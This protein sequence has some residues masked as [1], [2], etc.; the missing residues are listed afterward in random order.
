M[1]EYHIKKLCML[2]LIIFYGHERLFTDY[3]FFMIV[4]KST[5]YR[6]KYIIFTSSEY[7]RYYVYRHGTKDNVDYFNIP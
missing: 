7:Y 3:E 1:V 5:L 4:K 6:I 2:S